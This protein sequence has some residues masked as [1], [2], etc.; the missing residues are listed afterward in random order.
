MPTTDILPIKN[1][2]FD[3]LKRIKYTANSTASAVTGLSVRSRTGGLHEFTLTLT[4]VEV[5]LVDA[6][7]AGAGGGIKI[8]GFPQG[9]I[10]IGNYTVNTTVARKGTNLTATA[11]L[12]ASLGTVAA[13][14]DA[15]LT[16]TEADVAGSTTATLTAGAGTFKK[17]AT[18]LVYLDGTTTAK[19][20]YLNF[21]AP[22]ASSA[23]NDS[24]I[25]N[26]TITILWSN[27]G[28]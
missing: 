11:S 16:S 25:V 2:T 15:T 10:K 13:A 18:G 12:V 6:G 7:A 9:N 8:L 27:S 28:Y 23:G 3:C 5:P 17:V 20:V 14:A 4:N 21:A 24:V 1:G 26:G 19:D 22:D